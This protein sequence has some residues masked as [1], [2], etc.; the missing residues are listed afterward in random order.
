[1][2]DHDF[3]KSTANLKK[4]VPLM[5]KHHVPTTPENYALWYTYV[6][7]IVPE[8]NKEIDLLLKNYEA[9][10]VVSGEVLYRN[11]IAG[12]AEVD[13]GNLKQN[14]E[15]MAV[16]LS[17]SMTDAISDTSHFAEVLT[18]SFDS[19]STKLEQ[20]KTPTLDEVMPMI[21]ELVDE[22]RD[23]RDS[24]DFLHDQL[25]SAGDEITKLKKQLARVQCDAMFD[26]MTKLYNRGT[27]DKDLSLFC[28]AQQP[29]SLILLD[30]DHFKSFNDD[31]GHVFGDTILKGIAAR[32]LQSC[33]GGITAYRF[34]GEEFALIVPNKPLRVARQ[35]AE[36]LRLAIEKMTIKDRRRGKTVGNITASFGVAELAPEDDSIRLSERA[37]KQLYSAKR[38][39]RN[40]VMP[41]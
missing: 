38:A 18:T 29:L 26:S 37:D 4:A 11:H 34:G 13:L 14:M 24:T 2:K 33:Q 3:K 7:E 39:G 41:Y 30:I 20:E 8:L 6:S 27:F 21:R 10:P 22:A 25:K 23:I 40:R 9:M 16:E 36:S 35:M 15:A 19:I 1:M 17:N 28:D 32:L 31:L 5:V 12:K